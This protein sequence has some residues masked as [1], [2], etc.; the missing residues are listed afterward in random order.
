MKG[1]ENISEKKKYSF[2]W[3]IP[4]IF[5]TYPINE[6]IQQ[7]KHAYYH[8]KDIEHRKIERGEFDSEAFFNS[9]KMYLPKEVAD[10][11]TSTHN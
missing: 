3:T 2:D 5:V 8:L 7:M 1:L 11:V 4:L 9:Y 6:F 10:G